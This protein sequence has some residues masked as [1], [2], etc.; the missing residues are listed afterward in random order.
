MQGTQPLRRETIQAM[1]AKDVVPY[2]TSIATDWDAAVLRLLLSLPLPV[3]CAVAQLAAYLTPYALTDAL[4]TPENYRSFTDRTSMLLSSHTLYNLELMRNATDGEVR[5]SLF[6]HVDHCR[7]PMGK[8]LLRQWLR[9]PLLDADQ[10]AAR[11]SAVDTLRERRL[12]SLHQA[13]ALLIRLPDLARGLARIAYQLVEPTE[14]VTVLLSLHRVTREFPFTHA[15]EV[16]SG[17]PLLDTTLAALST[18]RGHVATHLDAIHVAEA[19]KNAKTELF[20][21]PDRYPAITRWKAVL[22]EDETKLEEHLHEVRAVLGRPKLAY[23]SVAGIENLIEV[24]TA[25]ASKTPADWVRVNSTKVA[26]RFHTPTVLRLA[27]LREQHREQLAAEGR[28]AFADFVQGVARDY[29]PMYRVVCAL[30]ELDALHS[31]AEV[32]SL[33]GYTR[34]TI[35][36]D[37][38]DDELLLHQFRH[39]VVEAI[40]EQTYVPNDLG[41]GGEHPRAVL[42]TGANMG[43][44]S[45]TARAIALIVVLAQMGSFVPCASARIPCHDAIA[46]RM[47]AQD[48]LVRGK[49]TFMVEAEETAQMLRIATPRSL[50]LLDEFGR[51]TS[52]FDGAA[53]AHAVLTSMLVQGDQSPKVLFITHYTSLGTLVDEFPGRI[54]ALHMATHVDTHAADPRLVFLHALRKGIAP[55]S[56]GVH[57]AR[58]AELPRALVQAAQQQSHALRTA[59]AAAG[60]RRRAA[61]LVGAAFGAHDIDRAVPLARSLLP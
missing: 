2:L 46:T 47:G 45:S 6:W 50:L 24:R 42:L 8:R 26:V 55:D 51:G 61:A 5:G 15:D 1:D 39:P 43:G 4:R 41:L 38:G 32:A 31:L 20:V 27:K 33:P 9:R 28:A 3:Q 34:P 11:A 22:E 29:A 13:A 21:D 48:D 49:S 10:I 40:Q 36:T 53:L 17:S 19:R 59:H 7:T 58:L 12:P 23:F 30:A 25:D 44:K 54:A 16:Q 37:A 57:V 14:L 60:R 56:L 52:T 18:A 35:V